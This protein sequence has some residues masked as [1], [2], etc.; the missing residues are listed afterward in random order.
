V[1]NLRIWHATDYLGLTGYREKLSDLD[2]WVGDAS[3]LEIDFIQY[4]K[5]EKGRRISDPWGHMSAIK[6][7]DQAIRVGA[8]QIIFTHFG[9]YIIEMND[10]EIS[11]TL[12]SHAEGRIEVAVAKDGDAFKLS[13]SLSEKALEQTKPEIVKQEK[14]VN[15]V[16]KYKGKYY[17]ALGETYNVKD[18]FDIGGIIRIGFTRALK[19][20]KDD[21]ERWSISNPSFIEFREDKTEP[22]DLPHIARIEKLRRPAGP[23]ELF[24]TKTKK[25][26]SNKNLEEEVRRLDLELKRKKL[27]L[28]DRWLKAYNE[29]S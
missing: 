2:V 22:D 14:F 20:L 19:V 10:A 17:L 13:P 5:D 11:N 26:S 9:P 29:A 28:V 12:E 15:D 8:Q 1:N 27:E 16:Y 24:Q 3:T 25:K 23:A 6:Q 4:H 18:K 21:K 7:I